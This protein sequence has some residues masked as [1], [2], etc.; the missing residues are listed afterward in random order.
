MTASLIVVILQYVAVRGDNIGYMCLFDCVRLLLVL[1]GLI[2]LNYQVHG[3]H[4][5]DKMLQ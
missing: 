2:G 4:T 1:Y 3:I 5:F